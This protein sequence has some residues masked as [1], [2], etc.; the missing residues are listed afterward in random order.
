MDQLLAQ[1]DAGRTKGPRTRRELIY[2]ETG[3][4]RRANHTHGSRLFGCYRQAMAVASGRRSGEPVGNE[5][6]AMSS[7]YVAGF[8]HAASQSYINEAKNFSRSNGVLLFS[9]K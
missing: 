8:P 1:V 7:S 4:Q 5:H 2:V 9:R 3:A 6:Q